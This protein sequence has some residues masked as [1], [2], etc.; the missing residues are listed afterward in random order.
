RDMSRS[1]LFQV[2]FVLQNISD[3]YGESGVSIE[4][5]TI[6]GYDLERVTSQFDLTLNVSENDLG[7]ILNIA[8]CTALFD[9]TTI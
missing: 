2:M 4:D 3:M 5:V 7:I 6:S 8:Y 9:K 1:P